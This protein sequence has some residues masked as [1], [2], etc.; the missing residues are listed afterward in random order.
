MQEVRF[1]GF[2][3]FANGTRSDAT[4][5]AAILEWPSPQTVKQRQRFFGLCTLNSLAA[6]A[7]PLY[8][9]TGS[10]TSNSSQPYKMH[11]DTSDVGLDA[12]LV[13]GGWPVLLV[14]LYSY[15]TSQL[16]R[17]LCV[18]SNSPKI[19]AYFIV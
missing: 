5:V 3:V 17:L 18:V 14:Y 19:T 15:G 10:K 2:Y 4:K 11:T 13:Q 12:V 1:L 7:A 8:K 6:I 9:Q 16:E